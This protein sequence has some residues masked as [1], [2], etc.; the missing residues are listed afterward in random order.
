MSVVSKKVMVN[1]G[2]A[3]LAV[4]AGNAAYFLLMPH[5]PPITRHVPFQVDLGLLIDLWFCLVVFGVVKT[6]WR[7]GRKSENG[8][9]YP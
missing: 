6:V 7:E 8:K 2:Q 1:F 9:N 4:L 3:L 5:L